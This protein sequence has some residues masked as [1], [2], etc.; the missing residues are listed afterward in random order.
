MF[1]GIVNCATI[2][3]GIITACK[4]NPPKHPLVIRLQGSNA[5]IAQKLLKESGL[6]LTIIT[7]V[8]EAARTAVKMAQ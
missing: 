7:D 8:D 4:E 1:A 6:P 3:Q 5:E 2:A